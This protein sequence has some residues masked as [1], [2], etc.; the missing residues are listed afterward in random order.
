MTFDLVLS[1]LRQA[2]VKPEQQAIDTLST[3]LALRCLLPYVSDRNHLKL[4][5]IR[6]AL[7]MLSVGRRAQ[8]RSSTVLSGSY[9]Y[10]ERRRVNFA[11]G[12]MERL[13]KM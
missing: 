10:E 7:E 13:L 4:F 2:M 3:C 6:A 8:M 11:D 5:W 12:A 9:G 1:V